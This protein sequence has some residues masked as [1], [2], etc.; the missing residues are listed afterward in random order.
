VT[1]RWVGSAGVL[2]AV[3]FGF[4]LGVDAYLHARLRLAASAVFLPEVG[5]ARL[6]PGALP[7]YAFGAGAVALAAGI[8]VV[9]ND[10]VAFGAYAGVLAAITHAVVYNLEPVSPG[11]RV[12][13]AITLGVRLAV[14]IV[15]PL[16]A[17]AGL[18]A[19][20]PVVR[21]RFRVEG[22]A[23]DTVFL[24]SVVAGTGYLGL[25]LRL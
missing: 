24:Q 5:T 6:S 22:A 13:A 8:D 14:R 7:N 23:M 10:R 12:W 19:M 20:V 17:E 2:P 21:H 11:D 16:V 9:R 25:G 18:D 4:A 3:S 15:G 1:A